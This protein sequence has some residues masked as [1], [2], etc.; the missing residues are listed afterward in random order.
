[1][2][3]TSPPS[4]NR[5]SLFFLSGLTLAA[6][7]AISGD[8]LQHFSLMRDT[9]TIPYA[10]TRP[11]RVPSALT[12]ADH[13]AAKTAWSYFESNYRPETGLVDS[14]ANYPSGTLWDQGSY[15]F[16]LIA[17]HRLGLIPDAEFAIR[18]DRLLTAFE[19]LPLFDG[20]L[21]NKVYDTRSLQMVDYKNRPTERGVG[22]SALDIARMLTALRVLEQ[23]DPTHALRIRQLLNRWQ[24]PYMARNGR[25]QGTS[26]QGNEIVFN[27]EGRIGYEQYGA[28]A[29]ALWG[30]DVLSAGSAQMILEWRDISG[31]EVPIDLRRADTFSAITPTLSEP[32]FMQGLELGFDQETAVLANRVYSAQEGRFMRTGQST[33]VSED[34]I[35]QEPYFLYSSVYSNRTPWA[36]VSEK[37][38]IYPDLRTISLKAVF[39]WD[40]LYGTEYTAQLRSQLADLAT[41][42]GWM[43]GRYESDG[44]SNTVIT[45]N[46]NAIV[47]ESIH[48]R[49]HGP[50]WSLAN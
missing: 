49:A 3:H 25:L 22:W 6:A 7:L 15:L 4:K 11:L 16:A 42:G 29:A 48:Y 9:A 1:M 18:A 37:G 12:A 10:D 14:V 41:D 19:N 26:L 30:M 27:Q 2:T 43:A 32:Y 47:L 50:M 23:R 33:M 40:A 20:K 35:D 34:N 13:A 31:V 38:K 45:A 46:T 5:G 17:A 28:R 24:L 39:A 44:S 36:V 8:G 21:P